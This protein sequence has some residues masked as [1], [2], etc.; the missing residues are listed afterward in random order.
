M[1]RKRYDLSLAM[2]GFEWA[3]AVGGLTGVGFW[4]DRKYGTG[5]WGLVIGLGLGFVGGTYNFIK[6]A[7]R[8]ARENAARAAEERRTGG[9]EDEA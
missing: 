4:V 2:L 5:P 6:A 1:R 3:A 7:Q 9:G 8:A